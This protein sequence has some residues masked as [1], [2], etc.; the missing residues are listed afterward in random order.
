MSFMIHRGHIMVPIMGLKL[1]R[2]YI[3]TRVL[4]VK[5]S[6]VL[7][8]KNTVGKRTDSTPTRQCV[9]KEYH[10][11]TYQL[12]FWSTVSKPQLTVLL[13]NTVDTL[14]NSTLQKNTVSYRIDCILRHA[15]LFSS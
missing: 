3:I 14:T 6:T 12:H 1:N 11:L 9:F 8:I 10:R 13:K 7:H 4:S 5:V 2:T 15:D